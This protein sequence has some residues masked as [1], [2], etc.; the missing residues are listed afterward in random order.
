MSLFVGSPVFVPDGAEAGA[1]GGLR[2][3]LSFA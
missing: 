1:S 2:H 3:G